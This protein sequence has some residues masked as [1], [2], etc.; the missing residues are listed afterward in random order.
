MYC[1]REYR[2]CEIK[3]SVK[4]FLLSLRWRTA[5][6]STTAI[7]KSENKSES[8]TLSVQQ[9]TETSSS[10]TELEVLGVINLVLL[11]L[12]A[13]WISAILFSV[14]CGHTAK[15]CRF[16]FIYLLFCYLS[17]KSSA[18]NN[19][20]TPGTFPV[21][22]RGDFMYF[23]VQIDVCWLANEAESAFEIIKHSFIVSHLIS[24]IS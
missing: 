23:Y 24:R 1:Q 21:Y 4:N 19:L 14:V 20:E 17:L 7:E 18:T 11:K 22:F 12:T 16:V 9:E 8:E 3:Q 10:N 5:S 2:R 13:F 15:E 6:V